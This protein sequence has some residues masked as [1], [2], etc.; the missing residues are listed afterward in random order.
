MNYS[1]TIK[2]EIMLIIVF[3]AV[4]LFIF[5]QVDMSEM[6]FEYVKHFESFEIDEIIPLSFTVAL[7]L[8]FFIVRR[9]YETKK[10][11][12]KSEELAIRDPLTELYNRRYAESIFDFEN[13]RFKR[14]KKQFSILII[15]I[16][17][18]KIINDNYGHN[19]GD[20]VLLRF[21]KI[22]QS[23]VRKIDTSSRWGGEE[24]L[25]ICPETN[26]NEADMTA[27]RLL[28][29]INKEEFCEVGHITASIGVVSLSAD[30]SFED[31]VSRADKCLYR[32]KK[33]GKNCYVSE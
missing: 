1:K 11:Y 17:N 19:I 13:E 18:F 12:F 10:L 23:T 7:S 33:S 3:N 31:V 29:T 8:S 21:S 4:M 5:M 30:E 22:I 26:L 9:Y 27:K 14:G 15:D 32:A 28:M 6:I 24:F 25:I 2:F 16:D 20:A